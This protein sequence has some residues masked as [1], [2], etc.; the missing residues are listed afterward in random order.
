M[1]SPPQSRTELGECGRAAWNTRGV[2]VCSGTRDR[3]APPVSISAR[4]VFPQLVMLNTRS[5]TGVTQRWRPG[6]CGSDFRSFSGKV[7]LFTSPCPRTIH[8]LGSL[9]E[10]PGL[11]P[12]LAVAVSGPPRQAAVAPDRT[13]FDPLPCQLRLRRRIDRRRCGEAMPTALRRISPPMG[14]RDLSCQPRRLL[15]LL[16]A[17]RLP[18]RHLRTGPRHRLRALPQRPNRLAPTPDELTAAA[19]T[20][21]PR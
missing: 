7:R 6:G 4:P 3:G 9:L 5:S 8:R 10:D 19:T 12:D 15:G 21:T 13:D 1:E 2:A 14:I 11:D 20:A 18:R 16:P 17:D